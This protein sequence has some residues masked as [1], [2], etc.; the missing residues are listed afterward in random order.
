MS[1]SSATPSCSLSSAAVTAASVDAGDVGG[2][3]VT[4]ASATAAAAAADADADADAADEGDA[5]NAG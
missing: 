1:A 2:C 3:P 4:I 5:L